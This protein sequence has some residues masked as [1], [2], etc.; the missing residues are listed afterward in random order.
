MVA[1]WFKHII[2][3]LLFYECVITKTEISVY[4]K[5]NDTIHKKTGFS[6][7]NSDKTTDTVYSA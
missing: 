4:L 2:R 3:L 6:T 1:L 7:F 5:L